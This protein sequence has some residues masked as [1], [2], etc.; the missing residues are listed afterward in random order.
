VRWNGFSGRKRRFRVIQGRAALRLKSY[1]LQV[2]APPK[3][4]LTIVRVGMTAVGMGVLVQQALAPRATIC[5]LGRL[6][7]CVAAWLSA[8][9][10]PF[11]GYINPQ[12]PLNTFLPVMHTG[13]CG[14]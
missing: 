6:T 2:I 4:L 1:L 13:D 3:R 7:A 12:R 11:R 5:S 8:A 10:P 14:D 9:P